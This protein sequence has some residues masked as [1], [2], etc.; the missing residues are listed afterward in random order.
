MRISRKTYAKK[1]EVQEK[2][3]K[4]MSVGKNLRE[5]I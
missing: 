5:I 1:Y 4:L 3:Q 2:S